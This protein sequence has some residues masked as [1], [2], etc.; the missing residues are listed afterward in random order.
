VVAVERRLVTAEAVPGSC[1]VTSHS[2]GL[3]AGHHVTDNKGSLMW[4]RVAW[5]RSQHAAGGL[6]D[7]QGQ[8]LSAMIWLPAKL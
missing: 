3:L 2:I 6:G 5:H 4:V 1:R 7:S 8:H